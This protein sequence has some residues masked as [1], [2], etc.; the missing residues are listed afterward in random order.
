MTLKGILAMTPTSIKTPREF[1]DHLVEKDVT[2]F[3]KNPNDLRIAYHACT[4][5]LSL[6]DWVVHEHA[7]KPWAHSGTSQVL[8]STTGGLQS[9]LEEIDRR[10]AIITDIANASKHMVLDPKRK[11]RTNLWGA[12]NTAVMTIGGPVGAAPVGA[13]PV[14]GSVS[15]IMVEINHTYHCVLE[16]VIAGRGIWRTLMT[17]NTW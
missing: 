11:Q 3:I 1:F 15:S 16:C 17:E 9:A 10:F 7:N 14:A 12:A 5:L 13:T 4:S 8:F 6:R 2:E